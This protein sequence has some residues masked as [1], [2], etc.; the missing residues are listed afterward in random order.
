MFRFV[1][2]SYTMPAEL[3]QQ[4]L[5]EQMEAFLCSDAL[6]EVFDLLDTDQ[7]RISRDY[8][9]RMG[10]GGRVRET[11][12]MEPAEELEPL[13]EKLYPLLDELGFL[14]INTPLAA[15][16]SRVLV[17]AGSFSA[18]FNNTNAAAGW[19]DPTT[20]SVDGLSCY[21]PINPKERVS[22]AF[23][24]SSDT[25][26]GVVSDAFSR[27]FGLAEHGFQDAFVGDRNLH[28]ISCMRQFAAQPDGCLY[29]VF[30][31]PSSE[32]Q[33]RRADT[34][35]T[36]RFYVESVGL[37]PGESLL[38]ATSNR[39]CNRQFLQLA[40]FVIN[41]D[42]PVDLDVAGWIPDDQI[43]TMERYDILQYLQE[44]IST[45]DWIGRF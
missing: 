7:E 36:L 22:C 23:A 38:A 35:D 41:N 15:Q 45:L 25:E 34:A 18:C 27:V 4:H 3:R 11:Q 19:K 5:R 28:M 31:A 12:V 2:P 8:N 17:L 32:P 6:A 33:L 20:R 30:A 29:R 10:T 40:H 26:F 39:H 24:S 13:R 9:G 42:L 43:T 14:R 1:M 44:L 16:H 21:R 37:L